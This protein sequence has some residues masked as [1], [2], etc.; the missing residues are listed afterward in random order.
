MLQVT[1]ETG[2]GTN[3]A[4]DFLLARSTLHIDDVPRKEAMAIV[5]ELHFGETFIATMTTDLFASFRGETFS[6]GSS[7]AMVD[8]GNGTAVID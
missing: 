7:T 2:L 4:C 1:I 8:Q 3:H 6:S 5:D